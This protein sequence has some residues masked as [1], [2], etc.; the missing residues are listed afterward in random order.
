MTLLNSTE[1]ERAACPACAAVL[2]STDVHSAAALR[3]TMRGPLPAHLR[4]E[5]APG[6]NGEA[7]GVTSSK[8]QALLEVRR[9]H[10]SCRGCCVTKHLHV[11]CKTGPACVFGERW[12]A[13]QVL[14]DVMPSQPK[15]DAPRPSSAGASAGAGPSVPSTSGAPSPS[16]AP[17][18]PAQPVPASLMLGRRSRASSLLKAG[19]KRPRATPTPTRASAGAAPAAPLPEVRADKV[20]VFSQWTTMLDLVE[21]AL[22]GAGYE[23]RRVDGRMSVAQREEQLQDFKRRPHVRVLLLSLRAASLGLNLVAANH[24]VLLDLWWNPSVEDQAIDRTHRIG[25]AKGVRVTRITV[26]DSVEDK[27]LDLQARK[28]EI[29]SAAFGG[30]GGGGAARLTTNDLMFLF[31]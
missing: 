13:M 29:V 26:R 4:A 10:V 30:G 8:I 24:V 14:A 3:S 28:R 2:R 27:I 20:I 12:R 7:W 17:P 23:F 1:A 21:G 9:Q 6:Q 11:C 16:A 5:P 18:S 15:P 19:A 25:Q 31:S 22:G